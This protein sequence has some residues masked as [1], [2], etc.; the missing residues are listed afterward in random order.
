MNTRILHI[1]LL[2]SHVTCDSHLNRTTADRQ[3]EPERLYYILLTTRPILNLN[4]PS[5]QSSTGAQSHKQ[6]TARL[7]PAQASVGGALEHVT[8]P[9]KRC[10]G[11]STRNAD[12]RAVQHANEA[13]EQPMRA[14][15]VG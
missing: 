13:P 1:T 15:R 7:I 9:Q 12:G 11:T 2:G 6:A 10:A 4:T 14:T 3:S 8:W 5:P